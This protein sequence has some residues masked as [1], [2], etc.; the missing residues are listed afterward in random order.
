MGI[1]IPYTV[2]ELV[3][4]VQERAITH[5][6][7]IDLGHDHLGWRG[8]EEH[9]VTDGYEWEVKKQRFYYGLLDAVP[10][11]HIFRNQC[12]A[13]FKQLRLQMRD[14]RAKSE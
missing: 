8:Y 9:I 5:T 10:L 2:G 11:E 6:E 3:Y 1:N 14:R 12:S 4:V 7:K 13:Q